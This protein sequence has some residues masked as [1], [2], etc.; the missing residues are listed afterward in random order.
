MMF[1]QRKWPEM[2]LLGLAIIMSLTFFPHDAKSQRDVNYDESKI[3]PY[4]LPPL[5][6]DQSGNKISDPE[7]W[8]EG[9]RKEILAEFES[10]VY[11]KTPKSPFQVNFKLHK[12]DEQAIGGR[13]VKKEILATFQTDKGEQQMTILLYLPNDTHGKIPVFVGLN[14]YGNHTV[15]ADTSITITQNW[16]RNSEAYFIDNNRAT[17]ASRGLAASSW[18]VEEIIKRGYG[19]ATIYSGD[20]DPDYD[21]GFQN[22]VH[23]LFYQ[24]GQRKP[25][26]GEWATIGAWA[27]GLSRAMDYLETEP[28]IDSKKVIVLGHSRLGKAALWAGAQDERFAMVISNNSGCGGAALSRRKIGETVK[29]INTSFPHWFCG[30]FSQYNDKEN[31]LPVDQHMLLALIAPRPLYVASASEDLWADPRG[32]FLSLFHSG[33]VY[34]LFDHQGVKEM[35]PVDQPVMGD[36]VGYHIRTGEHAITLYDWE[37]YMDFADVQWRGQ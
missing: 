4:E 27:W 19:V 14:F 2:K 23:P 32:E 12:K 7:Q 36:R 15:D 10:Q 26:S 18:P 6:I 3:P 20:L 5:L 34:E 25:E 8:S 9:R 31:D 13:A 28:D 1:Q 24:E 17:E 11:G 21:D 16:T 30:N 22:G 37:H 29:I 33:E 35:P